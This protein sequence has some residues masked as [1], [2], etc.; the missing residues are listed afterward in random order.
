MI[1]SSYWLVTGYCGSFLGS[2]QERDTH[3]IS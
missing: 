2:F 1:K 3:R